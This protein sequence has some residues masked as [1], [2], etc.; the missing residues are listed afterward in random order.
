MQPLQLFQ[1]GK[2]SEA[3]GALNEEVRRN[4]L[5]LKLRTFLFEL[6]CFAGEYDRAEKQLDALAREG[7]NAD[8]GALSYRAA[9]AA[10]KSRQQFFAEK[11][12]LQHPPQSLERAGVLNGKPF[13]SISD[14][15][16]RIGPRLE[17]FFGQAYIWIPFEHIA[18]I[19][20][21]QPKRLRDLIW[22]PARVQAAES[23]RGAEMGELLIPVLAPGSFR[24]SDDQV[25]LGR[26]TV[27][28]LDA[29]GV[30]IAFGQKL[31]DL[32]DDESVPI[33]EV[34]NLEL[35]VAAAVQ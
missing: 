16:P 22:L 2:L 7:K 20:I 25:R 9:L 26:L 4:P 15:D 11:E 23:F 14:A 12:Y 8:L 5:D 17:V 3:L 34:R 28:E 1:A 35:G 29:D 21:Q 10:E 18:S 13:Q 24:H 6:L 33:L 19:T 32:D 27:W 30:A 31:L